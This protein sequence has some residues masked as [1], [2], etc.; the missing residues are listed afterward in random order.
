MCCVV[1]YSWRFANVVVNKNSLNYHSSSDKSKRR[2]KTVKKSLEPKW[3]QTFMYSPVHRR[4]F[5][6]RMLE[7]T[8]W[9]QARVREEESEFL[10]EVRPPNHFRNTSLCCCGFVSI[11]MRTS[12]GV[13][14][15]AD[16]HWAGDGSSG[17]RASLVQASNPWRVLHPA[18]TCLPELAAQAA[19]E[20]NP[21]AAEYV[22]LLRRSARL[23]SGF[24]QQMYFVFH[25]PHCFYSY[26]QRLTFIQ[27]R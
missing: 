14:S 12:R 1:L 8:L 19:P 4:E 27:L 3:N 2:T 13:F 23:H 10:G 24:Y 21:A 18:S 9:D 6:E 5:R 7:I 16:P 20:S 22:T 15:L 25:Q 17:R 26:R 11:N